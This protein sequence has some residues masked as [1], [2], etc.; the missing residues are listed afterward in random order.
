QEQGQDVASLTMVDSPDE[1]GLAKSNANGF[2]SARSAALQ[3]VNSLLWPAGEKD[4]EVLRARLVHRDEVAEEVD[5]DAF[6]LRLA[7]LA[8]ERGLAMRPDRTARFVRRNMAI[9][10]AYRLGEHTVR[11]L[12]R[13][14]AVVCTYFRNRRG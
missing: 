7:E 9:Q 4:P 13:P 2:Q 10:L 8:A 5:E 11:P 14:E 6:V 1:T 12:P 3:V